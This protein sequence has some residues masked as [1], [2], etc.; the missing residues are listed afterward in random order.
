MIVF[1][2]TSFGYVPEQNLDTDDRAVR[3]PYRPLDPLQP[4]FTTISGEKPTGL[5]RFITALQNIQIAQS[6]LFNIRLRKQ[7]G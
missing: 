1:L 4:A 3:I 7:S 5:M 2:L 6:K